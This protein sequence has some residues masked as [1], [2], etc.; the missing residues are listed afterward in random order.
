ME[1]TFLSEDNFVRQPNMCVPI[2]MDLTLC[3]GIGYERM[4]LPNF[5]DHESLNEV[6]QQAASFVPMLR[7][8]CHQHTKEFLCSLFA[9]VCLT[10]VAPNL[11]LIPPCKS[12]C[13]SVER[14][15]GPTMRMH[16]FDW[17]SMLNCSQ[18]SSREPCINFNDEPPSDEISPTPQ[19]SRKYSAFQRLIGQKKERDNAYLYAN[20]QIV[21]KLFVRYAS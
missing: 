19:H 12:L 7:L 18:F 6:R 3:H 15:C 2:P 17:P 16:D 9:P 13:K 4:V 8:E 11:G 20:V 10:E 14:S 21:L 5:L 1:G